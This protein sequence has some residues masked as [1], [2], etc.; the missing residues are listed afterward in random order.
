[1]KTAS[2]ALVLAHNHP[3]GSLVPSLSDKEVTKKLKEAARLLDIQL[4]D[5]VLISKGGYFSFADEG[6]L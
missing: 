3:S 4:L 5:H 2:S 6:L 1:L